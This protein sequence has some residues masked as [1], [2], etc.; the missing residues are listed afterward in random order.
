MYI[1]TRGPVTEF[2]FSSEADMLADLPYF[3]AHAAETTR[4]RAAA[5]LAAKSL[6]LWCP[7]DNVAYML[8]M[9][10]LSPI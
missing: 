1:I 3:D 10:A 4:E 2:T 9:F 5:A 6:L 8:S 7:L